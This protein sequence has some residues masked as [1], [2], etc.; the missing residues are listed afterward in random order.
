[1]FSVYDDGAFPKIQVENTIV[2]MDGDGTTRQIWHMI[3]DR[4][5]TPYINL[6]T[7]YYDLSI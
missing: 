3:K 6:N 2:N 4:H 7:E 1:M 5:I